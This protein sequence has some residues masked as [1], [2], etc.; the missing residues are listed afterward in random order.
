MKTQR[1]NTFVTTKNIGSIQF[2]IYKDAAYQTLQ[3]YH[4]LY[5][6]SV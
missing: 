1:D 2:S 4:Y 3:E 5:K 6:I